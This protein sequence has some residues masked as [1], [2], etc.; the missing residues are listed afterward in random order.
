MGPPHGTNGADLKPALPDV[1]DTRHGTPSCEMDRLVL[2]LPYVI[3]NTRRMS[4]PSN[5]IEDVPTPTRHSGAARPSFGMIDGRDRARAREALG[6]LGQ[7][8]SRVGLSGLLSNPAGVLMT[9]KVKP[10]QS[11]AVGASA[12]PPL[13][14]VCATGAGTPFSYVGGTGEAPHLYGVGGTLAVP[15]HVGG[16]GKGAAP[17]LIDE[18]GSDIVQSVFGVGDTTCIPL[19]FGDSGRGDEPVTSSD[20]G[21]D[22]IGAEPHFGR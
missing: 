3:N 6:T 17:P 9:T 19:I 4:L 11:G 2:P 20:E 22:G 14:D 10:N 15:P 18:G 5:T 8:P 21:R 1:G 12:V 13:R 7:A 16:G